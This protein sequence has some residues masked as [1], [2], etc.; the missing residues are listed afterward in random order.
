MNRLIDTAGI[1]DNPKIMEQIGMEAF[2]MAIKA[3]KYNSWKILQERNLLLTSHALYYMKRVKV[4]RGIP[5]IKILAI[6]VNLENT[7]EF[8]IHLQND[9]DVLFEN[10]HKERE[11]MIERIIE[12]SME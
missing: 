12:T 5:L 6:S 9:Y 2:V 7:N 8:I 11:K 1:C 10:Y 4:K 3:S